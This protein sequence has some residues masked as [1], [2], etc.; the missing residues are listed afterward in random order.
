MIENL[1]LDLRENLNFPYL[2]LNEYTGNLVNKLYFFYCKYF[3]VK[4]K[5]IKYGDGNIPLVTRN[6][7]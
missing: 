1:N 4:V 7:S 2:N 5:N 6:L 3:P